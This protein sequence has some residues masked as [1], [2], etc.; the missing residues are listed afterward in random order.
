L[1]AGALTNQ[2]GKSAWERSLGIWTV[3]DPLHGVEMRT[4]DAEEH[5]PENE[6]ILS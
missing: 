1:K 5:A 3:P 4:H 6:K 2:A